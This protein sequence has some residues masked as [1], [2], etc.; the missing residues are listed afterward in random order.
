M[1]TS[2][3]W[4]EMAMIVQ[5]GAMSKISENFSLRLIIDPRKEKNVGQKRKRLAGTSDDE[6]LS[7][8]KSILRG[9]VLIPSPK[10]DC[11]PRGSEGKKLYT[12]G[13]V[14]SAFEI[15]DSHTESDIRKRMIEAFCDKLRDLLEPK[16]KFVRTVGNKLIDPSCATYSGKVLK[17]LN[18]QGPIY[19]VQC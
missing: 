11:V 18:K 14:I 5:I 6:N 8:E 13:C 2:R 1:S 10:T 12:Q 4:W 7:K 9:V 16:F 3:R 19:V 15:R 17:Y